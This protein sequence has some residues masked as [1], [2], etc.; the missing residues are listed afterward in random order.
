M[1]RRTGIKTYIYEV[2]CGFMVDII[3]DVDR[4]LGEG[5]WS[6]FLYRD[7]MGIKMHMFS[8]PKSQTPTLRDAKR[9]VKANL[10]DYY[11]IY[12]HEYS[13]LDDV[14]LGYL[15]EDEN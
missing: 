4:D 6:I 11:W 5:I 2:D 7:T 8:L 10:K 15:V 3:D 13:Q 9:I 12:D 14:D 1:K